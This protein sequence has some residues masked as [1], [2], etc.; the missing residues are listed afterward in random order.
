MKEL[1]IIS[2]KSMLNEK[3]IIFIC[4][5]ITSQMMIYASGVQDNNIDSVHVEP[6]QKSLTIT[7][8][9]PMQEM[10][11]L[12]RTEPAEGPQFDINNVTQSDTEFYFIGVS[13]PFDNPAS[14]RNNARENAMIQVLKFYGQ[15]IESRAIERTSIS[16][17]TRDT[18]ETFVN[19]EEEIRNYAEH[20]ISQVETDR[21]YTEVYLNSKNEEE[22]V[23]FVRCQISRQKAENDI[24]N[25]AKNISQRYA[26]MLIPRSTLKATLESLV[27]AAKSMEQNTLHRII[28]YHDD[29]TG[30]VGL[31]GYILANINELVNSISITTIPNRSV[32]KTETLN[33]VVKLQSLQMPVIGPF[34]FRV[35]IRGMNINLSSANYTA[36]NDNSFLILFHT[37]SLEAGRYTVQ[38][39]M[40]LDFLTGGIVKNIGTGFSFEVTPLMPVWTNRTEVE[41]GIKKAVDTLAGSLKNR[42]ETRIG[43]FSLSGTDIPSGLSRFLTE[44]VKHYALN[45][46]D[47]KYRINSENI[48]IDNKKIATLSGFFSKR[49]D[50]VDITLELITQDGDGDGSQFFSISLAMLE[51]EGIVIE[52]EN[53]SLLSEEPFIEIIKKQNINI[54]AFFN[55]ESLTFLHRD[56]LGITLISDKDCHFI[57]LHFDVN[58][59][60]TLLYPNSL[61]D[62]NYLIANTSRVIFGKNSNAFL[63]EPY[64]AERIIVYASLN[65]FK[66][67][68]QHFIKPLEPLT[69]ASARNIFIGNFS[70]QIEGEAEY[71]ISI[72]KPHEE[73]EYGKPENLMEML[74]AIHN[75][76]I[77]QGGTFE[78]NEISG[79]YVV[80]N[81]RG[82]YRIPR[83]TP[84]NIQFAIYNLDAFTS[85][86][87]AGVQTRGAGFTFSFSKPRNITQAINTVKTGI[88]EKG[89]TFT[90]NEHQGSFKASG[91]TGQYNVSDIVNIT[92]TEKP[93]MLPNSLIER[94]V[95]IFFGER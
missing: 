23:V 83:N 78:G 68:Q 3:I 82:S 44:R 62:N 5:F 45:N 27:F 38:I 59:Q 9:I 41:A 46:P 20:V 10:K 94:E 60:P 86:A 18:L 21:Y 8:I 34:E 7:E 77:S 33:T 30:R 91:I 90:G 72:L 25:F 26:A 73:Y 36:T 84:E 88:E 32:Q 4:F 61:D 79:V 75:D 47:R 66:D 28:A 42:T 37:E 71:I 51:E 58:N 53:L 2:V 31:Y 57:I 69:I 87:Q 89:G 50:R 29:T 64:G 67:I 95:K 52:P 13:L 40:L 56:E 22:Y 74:N 80:N 11:I 93:F 17:N 81:I 12:V 43:H 6:L 1:G 85:G 55:S 63:Y 14:A 35:S 16:G 48:E 92:I 70:D 24:T 76:A 39:E 19:R 54:Q 49:I 65:E 15:F